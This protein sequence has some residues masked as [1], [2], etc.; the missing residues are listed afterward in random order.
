M[1]VNAVEE[2]PSRDLKFLSEWTPEEEVELD[3]EESNNK[4]KKT[5]ER[6]TWLRKGHGI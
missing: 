5:E 1:S 3:A 4:T 6:E 2:E